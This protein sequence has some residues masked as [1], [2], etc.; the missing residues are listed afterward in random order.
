MKGDG[1][2]SLCLV[3]RRSTWD[4]R[5]GRGGRGNWLLQKSPT[6]NGLKIARY[7]GFSKFYCQKEN[8]LGQYLKL[9]S[10]ATVTDAVFMFGRTRRSL[11]GA[12]NPSG[13]SMAGTAVSQP[14]P[15]L[16]TVME[17]I[18]SKSIYSAGGRL[19]GCAQSGAWI[20]LRFAE[21]RLML[22]GRR[23]RQI[24]PSAMLSA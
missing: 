16:S 15:A 20:R 7:T 11:G 14:V 12:H 5:M 23:G 2:M 4:R 24:R 10:S 3:G 13:S 22:R 17:A 1:P 18:R 21:L 8:G 9:Y 6:D 19:L